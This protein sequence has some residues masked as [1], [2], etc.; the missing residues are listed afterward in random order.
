MI[1]IDPHPSVPTENINLILT[2]FM[3]VGKT[4]IG[5]ELAARL[6]REFIDIDQEIERRHGMPVTEIFRTMG[7]REFRQMEKDLI[8]DLCRNARS[9]VIS[10]GGGAFMQEDVRNACLSTSLVFHL[11]LSWEAWK[12][13]LLHIMDSRPVLHGKSMEEIEALFRLRGETYA[14]SHWTVET[15]DATPE[16]AADRILRILEARP[17]P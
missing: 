17:L 8:V 4:T 7:E 14:L 16:E 5:V 13:R 3:G 11:H 6:G 9:K 10:L 12:T 1:L 15:D 2:G